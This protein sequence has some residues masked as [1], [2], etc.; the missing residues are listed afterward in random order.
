MEQ[1]SILFLIICGLIIV[2]LTKDDKLK[3][4]PIDIVDNS[5]YIDPEHLLYDILTKYSNGDKISLE[6]VCTSNLY[7]KDI[8][9]VDMNIYIKDLITQVIENIYKITN[10]LYYIQEI[11]NVY[12]QIDANNNKRYIIDATLNAINKYYTVKVM[13]D[14]IIFRGETETFCDQKYIK[15]S[16]NYNLRK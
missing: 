15:N 9:S 3:I 11:N 13:L 10:S 14:I 6:G 16:I 2:L 1:L 5:S 12:E 7:T 8:L 4:Q